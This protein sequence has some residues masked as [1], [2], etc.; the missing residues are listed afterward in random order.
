MKDLALCDRYVLAYVGNEAW[1]V[2]RTTA[3]Q[4]QGNFQEET[5]NRGSRV[6]LFHGS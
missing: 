2:G 6:P 1:G 4:A 3:D 5:D